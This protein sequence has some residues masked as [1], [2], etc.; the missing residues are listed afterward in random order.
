MPEIFEKPYKATGYDSMDGAELKRGLEE[1][2][3][4]DHYSKRKVQPIEWAASH[5]IMLQAA[6]FNICK[7][8]TRHADK[9][10][11]EDLAKAKDYVDI[12]IAFVRGELGQRWSVSNEDYVEGN[13]LDQQAFEILSLTSEIVLRTQIGELPEMSE[14]VALRDKI[15]QHLGDQYGEE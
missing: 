1:Q 9:N 15:T 10:G 7:Y 14:L 3:G 8:V 11:Y 6:C 2:V 12:M 5:N 4:G 13:N